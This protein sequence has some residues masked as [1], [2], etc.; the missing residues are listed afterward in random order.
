MVGVILIRYVRFT[1]QW[2]AAMLEIAGGIVIG[3]IILFILAAFAEP[4]LKLALWVVAVVLGVAALA[5][6]VWIA[7]EIGKGVSLLS[8][9]H[10]PRDDVAQGVTVLAGIAVFL[11]LCSKAYGWHEKSQVESL[12][13]KRA[14]AESKRKAQTALNPATPSLPPESPAPTQFV[15]VP[16]PLRVKRKL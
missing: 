5:T 8:D 7:C 16:H 4:L 12:E 14:Y 11:F 13:L 3:G 1:E 6:A 10:A 2:S 9:P 15:I